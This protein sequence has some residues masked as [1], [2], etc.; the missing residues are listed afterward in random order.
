[1]ILPDT[2]RKGLYQTS[3]NVKDANYLS[4]TL[5]APVAIAKWWNTNNTFTIFNN[6]YS[7]TGLEGLELKAN[8]TSYYVNTNH[9]FTL[10]RNY[11]AELSAS[12]TSSL[13]YGT[14]NMG[15]NYGVDL[16]L[17]K[18]LLNKKGNLKISVNDLFNTRETNIHS[19]L[20]SVNYK[21][22]Q[23]QESRI[24]RLT[25]TYRF[26]SSSIKEARDRS[27]GL[28]SEQSRIKR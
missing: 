8:K 19:T 15:S 16:G 12:Y 27:T 3:A 21:L 7:T 6:Q 9:N 26:G 20:S 5:S 2:L 10:P 23:K 4:L 1:V 14:L 11:T 24:F 17:S 13:V 18:Q 25:F 28:E 22:Y